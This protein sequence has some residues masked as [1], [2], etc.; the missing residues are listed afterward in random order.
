MYC[1][2]TA[3]L[4]EKPFGVVGR[5]GPLTMHVLDGG[6]HPPTGRGKFGE[7]GGAIAAIRCTGRI[8]TVL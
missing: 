7:K 2:K 8:I 1:R 5:V 3:E 4:I 6:P